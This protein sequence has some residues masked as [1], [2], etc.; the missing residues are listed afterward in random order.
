MNI[1]IIGGGAAGM[2]AASRIKRLQPKWDVT[3]FE[4]SPYVS[5]A[6]CGIPFY[7]GNVVKN[8]KDLCTYDVEFFERE[9]G[10]NV[11]ICKEVE[12]VGD[13][14]L[15][16]GG[17]KYEW[18]KLLFAT[19]SRASKLNVENEDLDGISCV[20]YIEHG[21]KVKALAKD[22]EN[23]VIIGSGYIGVEMAEAFLRI[24]KKVTIIEIKEYPLPEYDAEI[25]A[26]LKAEMEKYVNFKFNERVVAFEGKDKVEKVITNKGE[27]KCDMAIVA[28][29]IEP[30]IELAKQLGVKIGKTGAIATNSRMETNIENVY[31]AGDCAE[32]INVVTKKVDWI[33]LATPANKMGYV[34]GVNMA[35]GYME[36]PGSLKSQ[37][38]G[39]FNLEIGKVGL[40]EKEAIRE[41][42]NVVSSFITSR[43]SAKYMR[44][45]TIHLKIVA[46]K[47]GK[48][49]GVQ[50]IGKDV[51]KRI[52]GASALLYKGADVKDFFFTDFPYYPPESRVW[53]PLVIAARSLF[54][55]LGMP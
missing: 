40:S 18:D 7:V 10:I 31:A 41:E 35:E 22:A 20:N 54:R 15:I 6:P 1:A 13:G 9:R 30:N 42:Y 11:N 45:G 32:S 2:A 26:I 51:A 21:E 48:V 50:C 47:N 5:H 29:G 27:Y 12:E 52:Y 14:Y 16:A 24:D 37:I 49:L 4:K 19:G 25:G 53:D 38:T 43:T 17:K 3:V 23:I 36:Y 34:A 28:V 33:P 8:F 46:D 39:F 55:K 44:D